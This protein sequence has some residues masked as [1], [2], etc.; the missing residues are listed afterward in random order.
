MNTIYFVV[1]ALV[2]IPSQTQYTFNVS[3]ITLPEAVMYHFSGIYNQKLTIAAGSLPASESIQIPLDT[4][5]WIQIHRSL[6]INVSVFFATG[7]CNVQIKNKVYL[8]NCD[9]NAVSVVSG[10]FMFIYDLL[11]NEYS[12]AAT[13]TY[14]AHSS[15]SVYN[16]QNNMIY[17]IGGSGNDHSYMGYTQRFDISSNIWI[18][19]GGNTVVARLSGGCSLDVTEGNIFYFGGHDALNDVDLKSI[20]KYSVLNDRW[21]AISTT[22]S[23]ARIGLIC[24]LL[25]NP[26]DCV[27]CIYCMG[28]KSK[29]GPTFNNVDVFN[30]VTETM[31]HTMYLNVARYG[32]AATLW[33]D[34]KCLFISGGANGIPQKLLNSIEY[35]GDCSVP[36]I[37]PT[38]IPTTNPTLTTKYIYT[39]ETPTNG[40]TEMTNG[41]TKPM[42]GSPSSSPAYS[43]SDHDTQSNIYKLF[44]VVTI[45]CLS[46]FISIGIV[47]F[48]DS[49]KCHRNDL[50]T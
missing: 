49:K 32:F 28:G 16:T 26:H 13:P 22:I 9:T 50:F 48:I 10:Q 46:L 44:N 6:P 30:T 39:S 33:N 31:I 24:K 2:M 18:S 17:T 3:H 34:G 4:N 38:L 7:N 8:I 42:S 14:S 35:Y 15:C 45:G 27:D 21:T 36:T 40:P 5:E 43:A 23:V 25:P 47:G 11:S 19:L 1:S 12:I 37:N 20:E 29:Y 41:S